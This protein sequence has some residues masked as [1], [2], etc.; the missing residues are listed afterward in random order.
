MHLNK[1]LAI[2]CKISLPDPDQ[3]TESGSGSRRR[4]DHGS[5]PDPDPQHGFKGTVQR[6]GCS[7]TFF[8]MNR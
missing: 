2:T 4:Y 8:D 6:D 3:D 5:N 7:H 1:H